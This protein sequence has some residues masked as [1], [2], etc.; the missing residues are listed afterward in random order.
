MSFV[1]C[2]LSAVRLHAG[3]VKLP[4]FH[5]RQMKVRSELSL[6]CENY[7]NYLMSCIRMTGGS[8]LLQKIEP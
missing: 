1:Y 3:G 2:L 5:S 7:V 6:V 8:K 4:V